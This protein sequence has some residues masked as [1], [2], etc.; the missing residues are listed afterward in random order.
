MGKLTQNNSNLNSALKSGNVRSRYCQ[1]ETIWVLLG[2]KLCGGHSAACRHTITSLSFSA[3][4]SGALDRAATR[5]FSTDSP[6]WAFA[7][8]VAVWQWCVLM[9]NDSLIEPP[10]GLWVIC[11]EGP[12]LTAARA[13]PH[14]LRVKMTINHLITFPL[15]QFFETF[16]I[17]TEYL[18]SGCDDRAGHFKC[19]A[20][21]GENKPLATKFCGLSMLFSTILPT[22]QKLWNPDILAGTG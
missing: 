9:G 6:A 21:Y 12:W 1:T 13:S 5:R 18:G 8:S 2:H 7:F 19:P 14:Q 3:S 17:S 10:R 16:H 15:W 4:Q 22:L 20:L 11:F